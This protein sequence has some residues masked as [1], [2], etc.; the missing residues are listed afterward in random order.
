M[1]DRSRPFL[2]TQSI[3]QEEAVVA[4]G[5][6]C[7]RQCI[8][9]IERKRTFQIDQGISHLRRHPGIDV[10]LSLQDK[11]IGIEA[12]GPLALY[13]LDFGSPQAG[14]DG[15]DYVQSNFVRLQI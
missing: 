12:V 13:A 11:V 4:H 6:E 7:M 3:P 2:F 8:I 9:W 14:L 15:A 10:W 5:S 1:A